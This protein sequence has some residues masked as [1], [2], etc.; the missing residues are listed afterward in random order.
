M[1]NFDAYDFEKF[2]DQ[3]MK[4]HPDVTLA[5]QRGWRSFWD[6]KID[7]ATTQIHKEDLLPDDLYG[8]R[9]NT[10]KPH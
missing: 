7:P 9:W 1:E 10:H 5:Q 6:V 8:F 2:M 3:F 4:E